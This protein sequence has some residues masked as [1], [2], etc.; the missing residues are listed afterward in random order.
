MLSGTNE[1][2]QFNDGGMD[3]WWDIVEDASTGTT[4]KTVSATDLEGD[5]IDVAVTRIEEDLFLSSGKQTVP[6]ELIIYFLLL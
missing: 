4:V 1:P 3:Y 5:P 6:V 2:P